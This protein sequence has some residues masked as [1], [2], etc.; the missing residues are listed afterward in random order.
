MLH[1]KA[2]V[3]VFV[4]VMDFEIWEKK[5]ISLCTVPIFLLYYQKNLKQYQKTD[6]TTVR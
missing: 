1:I 2:L 3:K 6:L 5:L 4:N